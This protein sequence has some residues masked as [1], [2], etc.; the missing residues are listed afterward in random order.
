M[1]PLLQDWSTPFG[2]AP[3]DT[4]SDDDFAPALEEALSAHRAEIDAIAANAAPADFANTVE[5]LEAAGHLL[6]QVLSTFFTVAGADSNPAREALQRDFSPKLWRISR[7]FPR[8]RRCLPAST[9]FG[10]GAMRSVS[11]MSR[12]VS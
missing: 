11:A 2:I 12:R 6:D 1:N 3:F 7:R 4:I 5:A 9:R 8:I 10:T